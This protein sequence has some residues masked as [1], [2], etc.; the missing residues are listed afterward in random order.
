MN[1]NQTL[2]IASYN[3]GE[4]AVRGWLARTPVSEPDLFI[5]SIPYAETRL[6]VMIVTRNLHEYQ[7]VYAKS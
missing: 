2:A 4:T 1:G 7:R 6:Y 3:A 5:D